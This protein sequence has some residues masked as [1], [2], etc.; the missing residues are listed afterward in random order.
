MTEA[1]KEFAISHAG[2]DHKGRLEAGMQVFTSSVS[3]F[4]AV[5]G[6]KRF[7]LSVLIIILIIL[8]YHI[9]VMSPCWLAC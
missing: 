8:V 7:V 5:I 1:M 2:N 6:K 3:Y 4:L 9:C